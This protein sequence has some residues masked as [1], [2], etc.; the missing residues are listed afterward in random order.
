MTEFGPTLA[1]L[2]QGLDFLLKAAGILGGIA[3]LVLYKRHHRE[4]YD[5]AKAQ[6]DAEEARARRE[7]SVNVSV[8]V[9]AIRYSPDSQASS[10]SLVLE[11]RIRVTNNSRDTVAVPCVYASARSLGR[12]EAAG[13][14]EPQFY[15]DSYE[16][17]RECGE[18]S[19]YRNLANIGLSVIQVAPSEEE[20]FV[21]WDVLTSSFV[22]ENPV[23][24]VNVEVFGCD[25]SLIGEFHRPHRRVGPYRERWLKLMSR[26]NG[27]RHRYLVFGRT[28]NDVTEPHTGT[29]LP[30]GS[31]VIFSPAATGS[32]REV[33]AKSTV[34]M[35][36]LV[37][38]IVQWSRHATVVV[39]DAVVG[40]ASTVN[41]APAP[42]DWRRR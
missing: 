12:P 14:S 34:E 28:S 9:S 18:L 30:K 36:E 8:E 11:T 22:T 3:A 20:H 24:V 13:G 15:R 31:R 10:S 33:D 38:S 1:L 16:D 40:K 27:V 7:I 21:R 37:Y 23:L 26:D 5:L 19:Q 2:D 39:G 17:L 4:R 29:T 25:G 32:T 42:D 35:Q 41:S 6:A